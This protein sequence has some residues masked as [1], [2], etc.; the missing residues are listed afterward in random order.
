MAMMEML[1]CLL[2]WEGIRAERMA[3]NEDMVSGSPTSPG[4]AGAASLGFRKQQADLRSDKGK[5]D[6]GGAR[7]CTIPQKGFAGGS[8]IGA[9]QKHWRLMAIALAH[10]REEKPLL[11]G[12]KPRRV[13][14]TTRAKAAV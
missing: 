2:R 6:N 4:C 13:H 11:C 12:T 14:G 1:N 10:G 5:K 7:K 3:M 9:G 8:G